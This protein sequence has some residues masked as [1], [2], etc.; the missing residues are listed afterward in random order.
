MKL[1]LQDAGSQGGKGSAFHSLP[2]EVVG[3][4]FGNLDWLSQHNFL[5]TS[6]AA[7][8]SP[9]VLAQINYLEMVDSDP[10][11]NLFLFPRRAQLKRLILRDRP[12]GLFMLR[13]MDEPQAK[14]RLHGLEE[15][16]VSVSGPDLHCFL[17]PS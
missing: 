5:R 15:L 11:E 2:D 12:A 10:F 3:L 8:R 13:A 1:P 16:L 4:I 6:K 9:S 17:W 14:Q 7:A